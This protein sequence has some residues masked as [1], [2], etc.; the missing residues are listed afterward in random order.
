MVHLLM[1]RHA[2]QHVYQ[3][4]V[5]VADIRDEDSSHASEREVSTV[6]INLERF[7]DCLD[8][9][10]ADVIQ[11]AA[12]LYEVEHVPAIAVLNAGDQTIRIPF[13]DVL[14][15]TEDF[16][17]S[18]IVPGIQANGII[19]LDPDTITSQ[20]LKLLEDAFRRQELLMGE[21]QPVHLLHICF[22]LKLQKLF[23]CMDEQPE[24]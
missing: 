1:P 17:N 12:S 8:S 10:S 20:G 24:A 2:E 23:V 6:V 4:D 21:D 5:Q 14:A 22:Q 11:Y 18:P 16:D 13:P 3:H 9:Q 7:H 15:A 19:K